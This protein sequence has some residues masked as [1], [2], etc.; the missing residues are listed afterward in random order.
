MIKNNSG[1]IKRTIFKKYFR[2]LFSQ[3]KLTVTDSINSIFVRDDSSKKF[4]LRKN[5]SFHFY[6]S[7]A[8]SGDAID[9][10]EKFVEHSGEI[11][12]TYKPFGPALFEKGSLSLKT[13]SGRIFVINFRQKY[14]K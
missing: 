13:I 2:F 5:L 10:L 8:P 7:E 6:S 14:Y 4:R 12:N 11:V 1:K 3:L 9:H